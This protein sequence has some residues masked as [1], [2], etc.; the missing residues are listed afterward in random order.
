MTLPSFRTKDS[1]DKYQEAK[2]TGGLRPLSEIPAEIEY[3]LWR[4]AINDYP[5]DQWF[6]THDMLIPKR[7]FANEDDMTI[8]ELT[9][10][11]AIKKELE[12]QYSLYYENTPGTRSV[13]YHYHVH[14][15]LFKEREDGV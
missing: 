1:E 9:E 3:K 14:A 2:T 10:L 5:G 11:R 7:V 4:V 6:K 13:L 15:V 8:A 12:H